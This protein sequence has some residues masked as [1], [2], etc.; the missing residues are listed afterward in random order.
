MMV[1]VQTQVSLAEHCRFGVG[2]TADYFAIVTDEAE[3]LQVL[4]YAQQRQLR[5]FVFSGGNNL[6]F[7]D[8]GF[9]GLVI[10]LQPGTYEIAPTRNAVT[11]F[12]GNELGALVR[13][14][15]RQNLGGLTFLANIPGSVGG[16][17]VGNAGCYGQA[18]KDVLV[19]AEIYDVKASTKINTAPL[20]LSFSYR[21]S[22]LKT[23]THHVVLA[24]TLRITECNGTAV[25]REIDDELS[26]RLSKHPHDAKCA[27][28]FF[29]NPPSRQPAWELITAAG[30]AS[31]QTGGAAISSRH[32]NFLI[33]TGKATSADILALARRIREQVHTNCGI[34][35]TTEARY[36]SPTG[37]AE[38]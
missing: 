20:D 33:N 35:L 1:N 26:L 4:A 21:H 22:R 24:A 36:I 19:S 16:A 14:L 29:T 25:L 30:M 13:D 31:A 34:E 28:S 37:I 8:A 15:A 10:K 18:M 27:G 38:I 2:G 3:F 6:F 5:F 9:R 11:V 17:V 32:A 7:D 12:A 23:D